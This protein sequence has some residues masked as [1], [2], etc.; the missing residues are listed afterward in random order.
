MTL[1]TSFAAQASLGHAER[2]HKRT[3]PLRS[4]CQ[5]AVI[6]A[7]SAFDLIPEEAPKVTTSQAP[8]ADAIASWPEPALFVHLKGEGGVSALC[9]MNFQA[10]T[11]LVENAVRGKVLDK[12][13]M[14]RSLTAVDYSLCETFIATFLCGL[15]DKLGDDFSSM[16][17]LNLN[18]AIGSRHEIE[19]FFDDGSWD[20]TAIEFKFAGTQRVAQLWLLSEPCDP[21]APASQVTQPSQSAKPQEEGDTAPKPTRSADF[22]KAMPARLVVS[23]HEFAVPLET[24]ENLHVGMEIEMPDDVTKS[25]ILSLVDAHA[26]INVLIGQENGQRAVQLLDS[27]SLAPQAE[28]DALESVHVTAMKVAEQ[29]LAPQ[30]DLEAQVE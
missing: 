11:G 2:E 20:V 17:H 19:V 10:V 4:G 9:V 18:G 6:K 5:A 25:G 27:F 22:W 13:V 3:S 14:S 26:K 16:R 24:L 29:E 8:L 12:P 1:H 30:D 15:D 7:L 21:A 23:S 28:D